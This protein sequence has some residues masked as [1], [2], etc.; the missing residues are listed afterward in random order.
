MLTVV[1]Y[2][3]GTEKRQHSYPSS[4]N[5]PSSPS[6]KRSYMLDRE[7]LRRVWRYILGNAVAQRACDMFHEMRKGSREANERN[8]QMQTVWPQE[9]VLQG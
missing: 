7:N 8:R 6:R 2:H 9:V 5:S 4:R 1:Q 3:H